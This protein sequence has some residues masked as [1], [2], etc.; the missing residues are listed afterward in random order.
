MTG[1][2]PIRTL[3][4]AFS[5]FR[6]GGPQV[7][8][9]ALANHFG[10][11][12]RHLI[13]A[14]DDQWDC[15]ARLAPG[16]Q[17]ELVRPLGRKRA[18]LRNALTYRRQL[19]RLR[20]DLLVTYNWGAMEWSL[21]NLP[22]LCPHLHIEDGFGPEEAGGQLRR[23]VLFRRLTLSAGATRVVLPSRTLH[24]IARDLWGLAD[25]R[26]S[27][28][29]NGIDCDR[30]ATP[31]DPIL[32]AQLGLRADETLIGTVAALR[33]E[34]NLARLLDA[35]AMVAAGRPCRLVVVGDGPERGMLEGLAGRLGLTGRVVFAGAQPEPERLLG[36][37]RLFALSSDTEQMPYSVLEAMAAGL[38]V[39]AV[40]VGD[41]GAML[42]P[43]NHPYVTARRPD[44]LARAMTGL[45][46]GDG[47]AIGRANRAHVRRTYDQLSM[48][49]AYG[50]LFGP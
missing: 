31:P 27:L 7:R 49:E 40:D 12:Y 15:V 48:F 16:L 6:V 42:A 28:I 19:G 32:L 20:P 13:T 36:A 33:P 21:A 46:D 38:P 17:V 35:F 5:T 10:N 41:V 44:A 1:P 18:T 14:L 43:P 39:A 47:P 34:K 11:R 22:P 45:L 4:H 24:A 30:F 25:S 3:L 29:P 9:A 26:L 50:R 8:F 2:A 37:W 23:R